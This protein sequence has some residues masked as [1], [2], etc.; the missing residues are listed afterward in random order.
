MLQAVVRIGEYLEGVNRADFDSDFK[1]QDAVIRQFQILGDASKK[2]SSLVKLEFPRVPWKEVAAMRDKIV[3]SYE[4]V[5]L[6]L[7]WIT[8]HD[9]LPF[10]REQIQS[11]LSKTNSS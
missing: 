4:K 3:H 7:I 5:D 10:L 9:D 1:T 11:V 8:A 6:D 2:I